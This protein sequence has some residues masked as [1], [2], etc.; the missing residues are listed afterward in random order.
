MSQNSFPTVLSEVRRLSED[1]QSFTF[2][3]KDGAPFATAAAGGHVDVHL[4]GGLVRQYSLWQW[5]P[6]GRWGSVAVKR[7]DTGT[8]GSRAMHA[9]ETGT[10]VTLTGPR[11]NFH[12]DETAEHS[13]LLAGGI[14]ATP[15]YAMAARLKALGK[16]CTVYYLTRSASLAAFQSTFEALELGP[17]LTCHYDDADGFMDLKGLLANAPNDAHLYVCGPEPLLQAVLDNAQGVLPSNQVHFERFSAVDVVSPGADA[18][19]EVE[20]AKTGKSFTIPADKTILDV[21]QDANLPVD[22]SCTAGVCGACIL[23]VLEGDIDHRDSVL[24]E[25]EQSENSLICVCVSRSKGGKLVL[26][27]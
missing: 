26:D 21:L 22:F 8:G 15:I 20:L 24:T 11:N 19:F 4:P 2:A 3:A 7:E 23:D 25:D 12:L 9:L 10:D 14:G 5:D 13:I 17:N 27:F 18:P 1:I 16:S 6:E